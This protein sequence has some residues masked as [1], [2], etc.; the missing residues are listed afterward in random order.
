MQIRLEARNT[1]YEETIFFWTVEP[2]IREI[3]AQFGYILEL[4]ESPNGPW[5][6]LFTDPIYAFGFSDKVTQRGMVD[7]RLYYR[8]MGVDLN[9][10]VFYSNLVCLFDEESN[11]ITDYISTQEQL[12]LRRF[13]GQECLHFARK[14]FGDRCPI[15]YDQSLGKTITPK[16]RACF[17]TT[18]N[19][20]YFAPVKIEINTDPKAKQTDKNDYGVTEQTALSGWTSNRVII[21]SDDIVVFFKKPSERYLIGSVTPTSIAGN[22]VRQMLSMTQLKADHPAQLLKVDMDAYTLDEFSIFRREWKQS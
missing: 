22:T 13:N 17:G 2:D 14:K 9:S 18:F 4:S 16:C 1:T 5:T 21:E 10:H 19:N 8:I 12:L 3:V 15:C 6:P 11:Y 7:Q 20:G